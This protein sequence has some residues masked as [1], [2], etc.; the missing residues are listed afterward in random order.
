M[1]INEFIE[2][3]EEDYLQ[4]ALEKLS[5]SP[6]DLIATYL[7][8]KEFQQAKLMRGNTVPETDESEKDIQIEVISNA[9]LS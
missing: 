3:I 9:N 2:A 4:E 1:K 5:K 6:K 8:A 7:N